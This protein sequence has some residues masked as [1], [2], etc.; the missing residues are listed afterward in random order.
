MTGMCPEL[1]DPRMGYDPSRKL[2]DGDVLDL[3]PEG[4]WGDAGKL[5][6]EFPFDSYQAGVDFAVRVAA[7]AE[8]R[9]H[10]PD[11]SIYYRKVKVNYFTHDAGG[12]T[13]RDLDSAQ[14]VNA[15]WAEVSGAGVTGA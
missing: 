15:L 14:A 11:I 7:L 6:R 13:Q 12:V 1:Y 5:F 9:G 10:H 8:A 2:T 3:K 4:W